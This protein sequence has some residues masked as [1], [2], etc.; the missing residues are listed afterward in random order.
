MQ[1]KE[2]ERERDEIDCWS[3]IQFSK[4]SQ[5]NTCQLIFLRHLPA[6]PL[7]FSSFAFE[8]ELIFNNN[9][10]LHPHT[11]RFHY[12][13][14]EFHCDYCDL[15]IDDAIKKIETMN[16]IGFTKKNLK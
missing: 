10:N 2:K 16:F 3:E 7:N 5:T 12:P 6:F 11:I 9:N 15:R 4:L 8:I 13:K 14:I 1:E